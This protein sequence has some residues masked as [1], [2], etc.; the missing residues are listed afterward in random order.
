MPDDENEDQWAICEH[1]SHLIDPAESNDC[2]S[3]GCPFHPDCL[4]EHQEEGC[5]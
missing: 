5:D 1:C 4:L 3:C 2:E